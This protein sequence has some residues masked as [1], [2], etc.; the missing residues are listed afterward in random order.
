MRAG[1]FYPKGRRLVKAAL[2]ERLKIRRRIGALP[3]HREGE[4]AESRG[5]GLALR[6]EEMICRSAAGI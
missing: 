3:K 5:T 1:N 2:P 6:T 4:E